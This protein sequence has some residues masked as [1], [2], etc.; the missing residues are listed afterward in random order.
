MFKLLAEFAGNPLNKAEAMVSAD[1]QL[2]Q[3]DRI[4]QFD[5]N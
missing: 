5:A 4:D 2:R 1:R 3:Q